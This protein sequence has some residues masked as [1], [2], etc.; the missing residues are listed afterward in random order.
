[1]NVLQIPNRGVLVLAGEG[2]DVST[3]LGLGIKEPMVTAVDIDQENAEFVHE[4]YPAAKSLIGDVGL[5]SKTA[6]YNAVHLDFCNGITTA[7]L[8]TARDVIR[9][10]KSFPL[11]LSITMMKG[12]EKSNNETKELLVPALSRTVRKRIR[13]QYQIGHWD[14]AAHFTTH[15]DLELMRL[16]G[17]SKKELIR[18]RSPDLD[19]ASLKKTKM[20]G[21]QILTSAGQLTSL[22]NGIAR[23]GVVRQAL[24]A[25][26]LTEEH[27][28]SMM[29]RGRGAG[30][31]HWGFDIGCVGVYCYYSR[32]KHSD[33]TPFVTMN[34]VVT[35][36]LA[37]CDAVGDVMVN[38]GN[39]IA[40]FQGLPASI[41]VR[42]MKQFAISMMEAGLTV[43]ETAL[44]L[45]VRKRTVVAW[46]AHSTR[47]TYDELREEMNER[48]LGIS[49][50]EWVSQR[51][52][53]PHGW[54]KTFSVGA[55]WGL[56]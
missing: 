1:M 34:F 6:N 42:G 27:A 28:M 35:R 37:Q 16:I 39:Q 50:P 29:D 22:G 51:V 44:C 26:L 47:G 56:P 55:Q 32:S 30:N 20:K 18:G 11:W 49:R 12:R 53:S 19:K 48:S 45:D 2:G 15:G 8:C 43:A 38:T 25:S 21:H 17:M 24:C 54:G 7:N 4:L 52:H 3:V 5:M 13:K 36:G 33:G 10:S 41:G 9:N 40:A 23:S 46:K 14:I 31:P